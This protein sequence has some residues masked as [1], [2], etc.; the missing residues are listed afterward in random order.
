MCWIAALVLFAYPF[1]NPWSI[2]E[3]IFGDLGVSIGAFLL[4]ALSFTIKEGRVYSIGHWL[5][6]ISYSLYLNHYVI[7]SVSLVILYTRF[8]PVPVWIATICGALVLAFVMN[9]LVEVPS[10][11]CAR[12]LRRRLSPKTPR[13]S[14]DG[15]NLYP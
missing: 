15:G 8:G 11:N 13:C 4:M 9:R 12:I 10:Q 3:R 7:L 5:G 1:D 6:K 14:A 2:G